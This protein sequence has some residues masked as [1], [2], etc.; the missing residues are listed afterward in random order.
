MPQSD[1][2]PHGEQV[3]R[4]RLPSGKT[5]DV[6][7]C[8]EDPALESELA[9][10]ER[11]V[12]ATSKPGGGEAIGATSKPGVTAPALPMHLCPECACELVYPTDWEE[13]APRSWD[14][15]LACPNCLWLGR[16]LYDQRDVEALDD[17]LDRGVHVLLRDLAKLTKANMTAEVERFLEALAADQIWPMDF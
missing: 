16:G 10:I 1:S 6:V 15:E 5:V 14:V 11:A 17:E 9:A 8:G 7:Y 3:R 2:T 4:L 13:I 12:G